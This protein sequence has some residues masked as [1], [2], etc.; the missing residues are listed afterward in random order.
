MTKIRIAIADD[1]KELVRIIED[2]FE[3]NSDI[4]VVATV[5]N[6]AMCINMIEQYHP[7]VLLLDNVMPH[8]DGLAVLEK[9]Q[10]YNTEV[11]TKIIMLSAFPQDDVLKRAA[12]YGAA[13]FIGKPFNLDQLEQRIKECV[14][15]ADD[16][17][18]ERVGETLVDLGIPLHLKGY[19]YLRDA[20]VL[21]HRDIEQL[22]AITKVVYPSIAKTYDVSAPSV[23]R[24]IRSAIKK[25]WHSD[26][27]KKQE[28]FSQM[29]VKPTNSIFIATVVD[30]LRVKSLAY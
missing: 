10:S 11:T 6:G 4:E 26:M 23:E 13:Y 1:S 3:D 27:P 20:I 5:S 29:V 15:P 14:L 19:L 25:S 2:F 8:F 24:A 12:S 22:S 16:E 17:V 21:V 9:M 18:I 30:S 28:L 7:D